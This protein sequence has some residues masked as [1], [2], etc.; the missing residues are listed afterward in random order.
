MIGLPKLV[1]CTLRNKV[2]SWCMEVGVISTPIED[3]PYCPA[4][5]N[6]VGGLYPYDGKT[7]PGLRVL[8]RSLFEDMEAD[9]YDII[10]DEGNVHFVLAAPPEPPQMDPDLAYCIETQKEPG[11]KLFYRIPLF[12]SFADKP[13]DLKDA[14][15]IVGLSF[16]GLPINGLPPSVAKGIPGAPTAPGSMPALDW[17]GGHLN[18]GFYHSHI[19]AD[20]IN[21]VLKKNNIH[22]VTCEN[23]PQK[24]DRELIGYAMDGFPIYG[25][26]EFYG[27]P[28]F[29]LD[30][31]NGHFGPTLF[32]HWSEYH[33]HADANNPVNI[34]KCLRGELALEQLRVE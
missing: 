33:Y 9:G 20:V 31:C 24:S 4:T 15:Q 5:V 29:N 10:D 6:D 32:H 25:S 2:E 26:D 23:V 17:C 22:E 14:S 19:I 8:N 13:T 7:N 30:S 12:P 3:G 16:F 21:E 11:L 34:P 18:E 27:V 1:K 28:A